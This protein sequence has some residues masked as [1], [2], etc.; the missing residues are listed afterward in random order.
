MRGAVNPVSNTPLNAPIDPATAPIF[1][2]GVSSSGKTPLRIILSGHP[3]LSLTRKTDLWDRY[4]GRFGDLSAR[5]ALERCLE[6]LAADPALTRLAPDVDAVRRELATAPPTY[7]RLFGVL[8]RQAAARTG[9]GRWGEQLGF[10]ERYADPIFADF[11]D[12]RMI[13]M[14]R[15]AGD[16]MTAVLGAGTPRPGR[17]GWE[18]AKWRCSND[19]ATRNHLH[20]P[21]GYR[22][23]AYEALVDDTEA[24]VRAV[25]AFV[26]LEYVDE[27]ADGVATFSGRVA[28]GGS[29]VER[30]SASDRRRASDRIGMTAWRVLERRRAARIGR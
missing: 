16:R 3:D 8:H 14:V 19:L 5:P 21:G 13:H 29:T 26:G 15:D 7:A 17:R 11:P 23:V 2:G 27:I 9:Q 4:Y 28:A 22:V 24:T 12:A 6:V 20:H 18:S 30:T 1:V 10:V 25:C